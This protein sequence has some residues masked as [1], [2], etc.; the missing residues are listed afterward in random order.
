MEDLT[1]TSLLRCLM[2]SSF[3]LISSS[4]ETFSLGVQHKI[5]EYLGTKVIDGMSPC[6]S[7]PPPEATLACPWTSTTSSPW[8]TMTF[9]NQQPTTEEPESLQSEQE[10]VFASVSRTKICDEGVNVSKWACA[11]CQLRQSRSER[12]I[13]RKR[14]EE[15]GGGGA[16]MDCACCSLSFLS[17]CSSKWEEHKSFG[18]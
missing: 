5:H 2:A 1:C 4:T 11:F 8:N 15:W 9:W 12:K 10:C 13:L 6:P 14:E 16:L 17:H 3:S 7:Q 18:L